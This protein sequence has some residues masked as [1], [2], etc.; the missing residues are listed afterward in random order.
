MT[1]ARDSDTVK[2]EHSPDAPTNH[3]MA[4]QAV[5]HRSNPEN[6]TEHGPMT[7]ISDSIDEDIF[8]S[9]NSSDGHLHVYSRR[10]S[11]SSV[12]TWSILG[13]SNQ[14]DDFPKNP[15]PKRTQEPTRYIRARFQFSGESSMERLTEHSV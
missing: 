1:V 12:S 2:P 9:I 4:Q 3:N 8:S 6:V 14:P 13:R 7:E 11:V 5:F 15:R 10:N